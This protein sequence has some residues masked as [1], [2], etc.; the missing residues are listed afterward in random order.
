MAGLAG[1]GQDGPVSLTVRT[2]GLVLTEHEFRIPLDH[3]R[4]DGERITVFAREVADPD[5]RDRPFL[6]FL[7]GGPGYEASRP[8]RNPTAPAF[9]DRALSEYR[10]L[11]LDQRGTGRS[12]PIGSLPGM[13]PSEQADYLT[14]FRADSI[15]ADAEWIR[16]ELGVDTWAVLGQS[17]GGFCTLHYLSVAPQGLRA[18][19]FTGGLPPIGRHPDEIYTATYARMLERNR[20]Y[21]ERYPD[22]RARVRRLCETLG[23]ED[24]RLP[25][26]D[27]LTP[28]RFRM[29][30]N[31]LGSTDGYE[32][33]HYLVELPV[34]SPTFA[35]DAVAKV[36]SF[37]RNPLYWALH[38]SSYSDGFATNWSAHRVLPAEF[39]DDVT[40]FTGEHVY[41]WMS[42]DFRGLAPLREAADLL[43]AH[44]W[45]QLYDADVLRRNEVPSAAAVY[46]E[47]LYVESAFSLETAATVRGLRPWLTNEYEHSG[48]RV[49]GGLVLGRLIDMAAGRI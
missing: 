6:V 7:A 44:E 24:I 18:A 32:Q 15:V 3:G 48:L 29:A 28:R 43:A 2:H 40:L 13:T 11:M 4:P 31:L 8:T 14:H 35:H 21:Y 42:E 25:T 1:L 38:E 12:T 26:G 19:Y 34:D 41:P 47:D 46:A 9:L 20:R 37:D 22:D 10:V 33:L 23:A 49:G 17:F 45:P 30:G 16:R 5:G 39:T 27:R 36:M